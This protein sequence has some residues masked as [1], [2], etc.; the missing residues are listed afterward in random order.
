MKN[1]SLIFMCLAL[2]YPSF[3]N[4][5]NIV[6]VEEY[7]FIGEFGKMAKSLEA[8]LADKIKDAC[9]AGSLV[10]IKNLAVNYQ[11]GLNSSG[12]TLS[13]RVIEEDGISVLHFPH[14]P[15]AKAVATFRCK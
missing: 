3:A 14:H 4:S 1:L 7:L 6:E 5:A 12:E 8:Q 13:A 15:Y 11:L 2:S 9:G 10:Q